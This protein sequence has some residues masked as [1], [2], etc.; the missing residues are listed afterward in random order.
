MNINRMRT[1]TIVCKIVS[2]AVLVGLAVWVLTSGLFFGQFGGWGLNIS[3]PLNVVSSQSVSAQGV[4]AI[5]IDWVA[6]NVYVRSWD[7]SEIQITEFSD[8]ELREG[9]SL[10]LSAEG[11][12]LR[13]DFWESSSAWG[14]RRFGGNIARR[15]L[16]V[17]VPH[18][19]SSSLESFT[20]NGI[21]SRITVSGIA[22]TTFHA[23]TVSGRIS[24]TGITSERL[25]ANTMSGRLELSG[26]SADEVN[27][28][29]I[30]GRVGLT[31]AEARRLHVYTTSGR[32]EI[33]GAFEQA[34]LESVSG[35]VE[36]VSTTL[37]TDL[38]A[39]TVSGRV[40]ITVPNEGGISVQHSSASG[41]FSSEIPVVTGSDAQFNI[42]TVSGRMSI[43]ALR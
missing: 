8:R 9:E 6:G 14:G 3:G 11:G 18:E 30:S 43:Y 24:L 20:V 37:P 22:A 16:E 4:Q 26:I 40:E 33:S 36:F 41:R 39:N 38:R 25:G 17:L 29:T 7:G 1:I 28:L 35:R 31:Q 5:D 42:S 15:Y 2:A 21:S 34:N 32:H 10:R 13:I 23:E 27:L 12:T 19:L